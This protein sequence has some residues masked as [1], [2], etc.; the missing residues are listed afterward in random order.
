MKFSATLGREQA[1][2]GITSNCYIHSS[3]LMM[4]RA[5]ALEAIALFE[6]RA[7]R[8]NEEARKLLAAWTNFKSK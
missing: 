3:D 2:E 1:P 8:G 4:D 7:E 6:E 5:T